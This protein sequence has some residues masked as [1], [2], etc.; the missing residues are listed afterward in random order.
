M[1]IDFTQARSVQAME[2]D[3]RNDLKDAAKHACAH[4]IST[5]LSTA[6]QLNLAADAAAGALGAADMAAY[7]AWRAWVKEMRATWPR[8]ATTQTD[9]ATDGFWPVLPHAVAELARKY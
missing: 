2:E 5:V 3:A 4:R 8:L 7:A 9:L 1:N 6:A